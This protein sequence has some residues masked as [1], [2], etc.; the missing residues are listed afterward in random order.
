[1]AGVVTAIV[2]FCLVAGL[3]LATSIFMAIGNLPVPDRRHPLGDTARVTIDDAGRWAIYFRGLD[4]APAH[5]N[6]VVT[7][8][9]G[10]SLPVSTPG[11]DVRSRGWVWAGTFTT[12][13]AGSFTVH[14]G[15]GT[16]ATA[17]GVGEPPDI[18]GFVTWLV[19]GIV[20]FFLILGAGIGG[21]VYLLV[22]GPR[23]S[24]PTPTAATT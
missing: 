6:C 5:G 9:D 10:A 3:L 20:G 4:E 2:V 7:A 22:R 24:R 13:S 23:R 17:F 21:G 15:S 14:C 1:M 16:G 8:P 19:V 12:A 18:S 11:S